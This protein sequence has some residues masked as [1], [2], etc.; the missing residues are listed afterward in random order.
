M[1]PTLEKIHDYADSAH[2]GQLRRFT[3]DRYIVHPIRV[4]LTCRDYT[5]SLPVLAAAL[6]HDVLEDTTVTADEMLAF[7]NTVMADGDAGKTLALVIEMTDVY[8]RAAYPQHNR[9]A[10]K[11]MELERIAL[12]SPEAQT[13]KY[14][15]ILDNSTELAAEDPN[16]APRY[17]R[18]C[19]A[20]LTVA[21]KGH[22]ELHAMAMETVSG[23]L[24][25]L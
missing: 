20:I 19:L 9:K 3:P 22:P 13:I 1:H 18:E 10:R 4:M 14:A 7:L 6:L 25:Q 11:L 21:D 12:T 24:A 8:V 17:L 2:G 15:D 5:E 16:F 23:L